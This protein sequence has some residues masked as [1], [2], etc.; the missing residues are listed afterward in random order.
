[1][2]GLADAHHCLDERVGRPFGNFAGAAIG[3]LD[4]RDEVVGRGTTSGK[5]RFEFSAQRIER[6]SLASKQLLGVEQP[7]ER[8]GRLPFDPRYIGRDIS[9]LGAAGVH[10]GIE[11]RKGGRQA[12]LNVARHRVERS[13]QCF[14]LADHRLGRRAAPVERA[15]QCFGVGGK[16]RQRRGEP[17]VACLCT[18]IDGRKTGIDHV[19]AQRH[20]IDKPGAC[21][22][23]TGKQLTQ[24][25]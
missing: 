4:R 1:M 19:H 15:R 10:I 6:G 5:A 17:V 13:H 20:A 3:S 11:P 8:S 18:R 22:L 14:G 7:V 23:V 24:R 9:D 25:L 16:A 2:G 21:I 12:F